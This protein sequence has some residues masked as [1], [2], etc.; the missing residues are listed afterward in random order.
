MNMLKNLHLV[1][2]TVVVIPIAFVYGS[3]NERIFTL[4]FD[5]SPQTTDMHNIFRAIMCL[6]LG[7][8]AL[9]IAGII[10]QAFWKAAT[11][12]N[13]LFMASLALGRLVSFAFDGPPS[14]V[15]IIGFVGE[16]LLAILALANLKKYKTN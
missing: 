14:V 11:I 5:F 9:W 13:L 6:Y 7:M 3:G 16:S 8:S 12:T 15:L 1:I 10:K 4:F 2:S